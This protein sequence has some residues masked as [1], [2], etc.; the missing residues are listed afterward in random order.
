VAEERSQQ[1]PIKLRV[2]QR[3]EGKFPGQLIDR[4]L[5]KNA[6]SMELIMLIMLRRAIIK[7][8]HAAIFSGMQSIK[9]WRRLYKSDICHG[10]TSVTVLRITV[11]R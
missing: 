11:R 10:T 4:L 6:C 9:I 8:I 5:H 1:Q 3:W 7:T 2:S